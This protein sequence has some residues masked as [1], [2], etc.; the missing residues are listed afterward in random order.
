M[1]RKDQLKI[2]Q[3]CKHRKMDFS[4]GLLCGLT[5][6]FAD[7]EDSCSSFKEDST[8]TL[9]HTSDQVYFEEGQAKTNTVF[10]KYLLFFVLGIIGLSLIFPVIVEKITDN[11]TVNRYYS[12]FEF[13]TL[14]ILAWLFIGLTTKNLKPSIIASAVYAISLVLVDYFTS[15]Y[16]TFIIF[17]E[18]IPIAISSICFSWLVFSDKKNTVR[19]VLVAIVI[20]LS[21]EPIH[22]PQLRFFS[23]EYRYLFRGIID[24]EE[25]IYSTASFLSYF[26]RFTLPFILL[27]L[28]YIELTKQKV[29][30]FSINKVSLLNT[31]SN[32][33]MAL[34][35][36]VFY[37]S[38]LLLAFLLMESILNLLMFTSSSALENGFDY[39]AGMYLS[40]KNISSF[41]FL[42]FLS[43]YFRKI[44]VAYY[45]ESNRPIL[46][47][48]FFAMA[49]VINIFIWTFNLLNFKPTT[50][51]N[52]HSI[53]TLLNT[54]S[55]SLAAL[56][57]FFTLAKLF[58]PLFN[59]RFD[60]W[61][62]ILLII[63]FILILFY[64]SN[65]YGLY[66]LFG[67][68]TLLVISLI[69]FQNSGY[70]I[71]QNVISLSIFFSMMR[72]ILVYPVFHGEE[73]KVGIPKHT[74]KES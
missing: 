57:I 9:K 65:K 35:V 64:L 56:I 54:K 23:K 43:W 72:L 46:W 34:F 27:S 63:D 5:N 41:C 6:E 11:I 49:P 71:P 74:G 42:V 53:A 36:L 67:L 20:Y 45:L 52:R 68:E 70:D 73:F 8:S 31:F 55:V 33:N 25:L 17:S 16:Y 40:L 12:F 66:V 50:T 1:D 15:S 47:N 44:T 39:T 51:Y 22:A 29:V 10:G 19:F 58:F 62:I 59:S 21:M 3:Q 37:T 26:V 4:R 18:I 24:F 38:I 48:Y 7:F 14:S 60:S 2:C 61:D 30:K 32:K 13:Y 69:F 28:L